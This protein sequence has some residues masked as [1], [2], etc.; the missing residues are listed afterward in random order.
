[1]TKLKSFSVKAIY[2]NGVPLLSVRFCCFSAGRVFVW[3]KVMYH[4]QY[5]FLVACLVIGSLSMN[6]SCCW[7]FHFLRILLFR[8]INIISSFFE[9]CAMSAINGIEI[10]HQKT[11]ILGMLS[12]KRRKFN[13]I[14][15]KSTSNPIL[16]NALLISHH[17]VVF[18]VCLITQQV[19][20]KTHIETRV[21][22]KEKQSTFNLINWFYLST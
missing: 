8:A 20:H 13:W 9:N 12:D 15:V 5:F 17:W 14:S 11:T 22:G 18:V 6:C 21:K 2:S 10:F 19:N 7:S 3:P 4:S 16:V 1:M